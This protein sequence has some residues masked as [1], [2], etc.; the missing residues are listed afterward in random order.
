MLKEK[1]LKFAESEEPVC[2]VVPITGKTSIS[3]KGILS[4]YVTLDLYCIE[5]N[6]SLVFSIDDVLSVDNSV[7]RLTN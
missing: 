7:I 2:V 4:Y 3:I 6:P 5:G 1:L